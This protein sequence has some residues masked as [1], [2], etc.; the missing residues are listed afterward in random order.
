MNDKIIIPKNLKKLNLPIVI[1]RGA[2]L[3]V[4]YPGELGVPCHIFFK[5]IKSEFNYC[6]FFDEVNKVLFLI[7]SFFN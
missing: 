4:L 5:K 3:K 1:I 2:V 7:T 6:L